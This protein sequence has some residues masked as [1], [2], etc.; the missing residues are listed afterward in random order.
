[1]PE[2][3]KFT[4]TTCKYLIQGVLTVDTGT[5]NSNEEAK[6]IIN[7]TLALVLFKDHGESFDI[8]RIEKL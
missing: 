2:K 8:R 1:M 5:V 7:D 6:E 4:G 3:P